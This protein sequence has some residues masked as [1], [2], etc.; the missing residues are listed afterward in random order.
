[1]ALLGSAFLGFI[2]SITEYYVERRKA[3][4]EFWLQA[5]KVLKEL[6][7]VKYLEVDA[8]LDLII[9]AFGDEYL[10]E[11]NQIVAILP[12]DKELRHEAKDNLISWYEVNIPLPFDENTDI[13]KELEQLYNF[14]MEGYKKSFI[15][16]MDSY[17][18]ASS[19][20]LGLLDNAYG[21]LD[22]IF[23]NRC[24]RKEAYDSILDK[25]RKI[26]FQ[27]RTETYHFNLLAEG[28]GNLPVCAQKVSDLNQEYFLSKEEKTH[29]YANTLIY[30]NV[31]DDVDASLEKFRCKIYRV[32]YV[33][34]KRRPIFSKTKYFGEYE[35]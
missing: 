30:Q 3:M 8:P 22:F 15:Q 27:F 4:E 20:E 2:M 33:E 11:W 29:G 16:C 32:K 19:V 34:P 35:E 10:N 31:F 1:M 14:N 17:R 18:V 13:D 9:A 7:K 5:F 12:E 26:I 25:L 6:R 24:V 21:N 28:K 23:A